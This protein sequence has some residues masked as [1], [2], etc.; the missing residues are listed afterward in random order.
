MHQLDY[1]GPIQDFH[2][3]QQVPLESKPLDTENL[4][5]NLLAVDTILY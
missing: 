3:N 1:P 5:R 4:G 2:V